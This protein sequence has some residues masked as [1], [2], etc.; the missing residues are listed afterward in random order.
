MVIMMDEHFDCFGDADSSA[1]LSPFRVN[2]L[3]RTK[4]I[5]SDFSSLSALVMAEPDGKAPPTAWN[6][7]SDLAIIALKRAGFRKAKGTTWLVCSAAWPSSQYI[8]AK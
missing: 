8:R 6:S 7:V 3:K 1:V 4:S 5:I 2:I